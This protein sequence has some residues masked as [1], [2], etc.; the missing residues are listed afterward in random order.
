MSRVGHLQLALVVGSKTKS[1]DVFNVLFG[2]T[3]ILLG[4]F[5]PQGAV[6][7]SWRWGHFGSIL[8][9]NRTLGPFRHPNGLFWPHF[10]GPFLSCVIQKGSFVV[11]KAKFAFF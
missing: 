11:Y 8:G 3:V 5:W 2:Y 1:A 9:Q 10:K 4:P 7:A 6:L